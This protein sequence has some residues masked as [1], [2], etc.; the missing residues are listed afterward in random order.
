MGQGFPSPANRNKAL[1]DTG[2]SAMKASL[3]K[4]MPH[5]YE[6]GYGSFTINGRMLGHGEPIR[7]KHGERVLFHVLNGS[8]TEIRSLALPGH[9]FQVIALDG[10]P[11]PNAVPVPVLWLGNAE[12]ISGIVEMKHPGGWVLGGLD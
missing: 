4:G 2:E 1:E 5:G 3:A 7:V 9:T 12:R 11:V 10:N 6:V 8:A